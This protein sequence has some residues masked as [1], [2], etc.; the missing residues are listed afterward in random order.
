MEAAFTQLS[1]TGNCGVAEIL[2]LRLSSSPLLALQNLEN[3]LRTGV[4]WAGAPLVNRYPYPFVTFTGRVQDLSKSYGHAF[5]AYIRKFE[6]GQVVTSKARR[7]WTGNMIQI[8]V[9]TPDYVKLWEHLEACR[10]KG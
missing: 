1:T 2:G 9:W 10:E 3:E 4:V 5:A 8:W 7:N 6:L